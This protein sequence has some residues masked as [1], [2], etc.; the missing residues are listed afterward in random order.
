MDDHDCLSRLDL[1]QVRSSSTEM[2]DIVDQS[3]ADWSDDKSW[4]VGSIGYL[5]LDET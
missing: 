4:A 5:I 3:L 1:G 2:N